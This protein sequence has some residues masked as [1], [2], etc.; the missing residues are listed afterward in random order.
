MRDW[1]TSPRSN[2]YEAL[3]IT[4]VGPRSKWVEVQIRSERMHEIAEKGFAAHYMYKGGNKSETGL[5]EWLNRLQEVLENTDTDAID[6]VEDF[7]LNLYSTEIFVFTPAGELK[8]L[9]KGSTALDF[10]FSVHTGLGL[11]TRGVKVNG[12]MVPLSHVLISGC[13]LYTSPS[14]RD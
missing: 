7:K 12:K 13:L 5:E 14:P 11:K 2:G 9:A 3:H 10:A 1:I 8:S 4:V 6:F